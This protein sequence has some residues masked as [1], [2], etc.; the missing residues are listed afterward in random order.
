MVLGDGITE[1][2][3]RIGKYLITQPGLAFDFALVEMAQ[4]VWNDEGGCEH[5]IVQPRL[6]ATTAVIERAAIRNEAQVIIED[7]RDEPAAPAP[8]EVISRKLDPAPQQQWRAFA[9]KFIA[10]VTFD[11]P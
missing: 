10:S 7:L 9:E 6:L 11:D 2:T 3:Q 5:T 8:G 1:G 4:Y